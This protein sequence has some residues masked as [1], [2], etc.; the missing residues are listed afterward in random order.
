MVAKIGRSS[1]LFGTL[2]YN[3]EKIEQN[4][5]EIIM[6]N[7]IIETADG[8]YS[9]SQLAKSFDLYLINNRNTEKHTLHISLNPDPKDK[10]PDEKYRE[11]AQQYMNE[12]GYGNQPFVVFKHADI[13]RS[14]IHIVSVCVD[15]DGKKIS[16]KF[17]K[18]KSMKTCRMLEEKFGL[19]NAADGKNHHN[20]KIF[21]PVNYVSGDV[22]SQIASVVRYLSLHYKFQSFGEYNALLSVYNITSEKVEGLLQGKSQ[23]GLLYFPTDHQGKKSGKPFKSSL[24]GKNSGLQML[25][26][27]FDIC[28]AEMKNSKDRNAI[29]TEIIKALQQTNNEI[30]FKEKLS[31]VGVD[32]VVYKN[33][34]GRVFGITFIDHN[35]KS[36]WKGSQLGKDFSA[37]VFNEFWNDQKTPKVDNR[38]EKDIINSENPGRI[39]FEEH[40][41]VFEFINQYEKNNA[42]IIDDFGGLLPL[43]QAEDFEEQEFA[44]K[45]KK[46]KKLRK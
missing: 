15:E 16:D 17:E 26:K 25:Q 37:N 14:H 38:T 39:V 12:M 22:K 8:K 32:T 42:S 46:R 9:V 30:S 11:M 33:D 44:K 27:H 29:R 34:S 18:I 45:L 20:L 2:S 1:N 10:V 28:K 4:K 23:K 36:V 41:H 40:L 13:D 3:N 7:K 24:F 43:L 21:K 19:R 6:T 35:A 31:H 5:G